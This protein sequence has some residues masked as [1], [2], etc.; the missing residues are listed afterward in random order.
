MLKK[1]LC[2]VATVL[3]LPA[4][5]HASNLYVHSVKAPIYVAPDI[6]SGRV[7]VLKKGTKLT[8]IKEKGY[9]YK[10]DY[11][12]KKGWVYKFMVKKGQ[13]ISKKSVYSRLK[14]L[15]QKYE[16]QSDKARRR[17]S[18]Y[19]ATAAARGLKGKRRRFADKYNLDYI[20][21]EKM[22]AIEVTDD[23]AIEFITR[24]ISNE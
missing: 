16:A 14:S 11:N 15:F 7:A 19:T 10:V 12:G 8:W 18:S 5:S 22:E 24:G 20:S 13:P 23:E 17:P 4:F 9:W 3:F 2:L 21:L 1:T 6:S